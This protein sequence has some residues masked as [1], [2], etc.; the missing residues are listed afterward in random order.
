M[1]GDLE[2]LLFQQECGT[3]ARQYELSLEG[4]PR[5]LLQIRR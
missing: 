4:A 3:A 5:V 2:L 1:A